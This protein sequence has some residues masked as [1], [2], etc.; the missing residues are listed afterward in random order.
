MTDNEYME[1]LASG[2]M[3]DLTA[4]IA[5]QLDHRNPDVPNRHYQIHCPICN[6]VAKMGWK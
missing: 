6:R 4:A 1:F 2:P 3:Q 5:H